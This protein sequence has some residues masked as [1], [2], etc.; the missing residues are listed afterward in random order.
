MT[1]DTQYSRSKIRVENQIDRL[2][3]TVLAS[4]EIFPKIIDQVISSIDI[5][6]LDL[7][8]SEI[9]QATI[10]IVRS[11]QANKS[12]HQ[13]ANDDWLSL[14]TKGRATKSELIASCENLTILKINFLKPVIEYIFISSPYPK[15]QSSA[16]ATKFLHPFTH[17][18]HNHWPLP[19]LQNFS[20]KNLLIHRAA[21]PH[22]TDPNE[23]YIS[24]WA[25]GTNNDQTLVRFYL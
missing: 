18:N 3:L 14:I 11:M 16:L 8:F 6:G 2:K 9:S 21:N 7:N 4:E 1:Q 12:T 25:L 23:V 5:K 17:L 22:P 20:S 10:D 13:R 24:A 15:P 19:T